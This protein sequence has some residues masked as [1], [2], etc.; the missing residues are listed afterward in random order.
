MR[1]HYGQSSLHPLHFLV[2]DW[3]FGLRIHF[4]IRFLYRDGATIKAG[5]KHT[6]WLGQCCKH[7]WESMQLP[8][9]RVSISIASHISLI[10]WLFCI[11]GEMFLSCS[12]FNAVVVYYT[13]ADKL[14]FSVVPQPIC[15][16]VPEETAGKQHSQSLQCLEQNH[17]SPR[18]TVLTVNLKTKL[19]FPQNPQT[20]SDGFLLSASLKILSRVKTA[21]LFLFC[22]LASTASAVFYSVLPLKEERLAAFTAL[23]YSWLTSAGV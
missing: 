17:V 8:W 9:L 11:F 12:I 19:H 21:F 15:T 4:E 1:G 22:C 20:L 18:K 3:V 16:E 2:E 23:L 7:L 13:A 14:V 10:I 6:C 5:A